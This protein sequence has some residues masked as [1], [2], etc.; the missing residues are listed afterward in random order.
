M[1][2][3]KAKIEKE[4]IDATVRCIME[5]GWFEGWNAAKDKFCPDLKKLALKNR[6][7]G[8]I[9]GVGTTIGGYCIYKTKIAPKIE[10]TRKETEP[11]EIHVDDVSDV[12]MD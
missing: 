7:F 5:Q 9:L 11:Y 2:E 12:S 3:T 1:D 10:E 8:F 4:A 6:R